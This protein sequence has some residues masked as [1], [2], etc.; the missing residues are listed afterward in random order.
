[1]LAYK[2]AAW[3]KQQKSP[4]QSVGLLIAKKYFRLAKGLDSLAQPRN[5]S[6]CCT[7]VNNLFGRGLVQHG[8]GLLQCSSS[9]CCIIV[10]NGQAN[11]LN[12]VL[13][14]GFDHSVAVTG[15]ETLTMSL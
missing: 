1:M 12:T 10:F 11:S 8:R 9:C 4:A 7:P 6:G 14:S 2:N 15:L 13:D 3:K 5:F